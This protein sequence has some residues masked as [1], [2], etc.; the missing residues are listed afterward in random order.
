MSCGPA[1][2]LRPVGLLSEMG[3]TSLLPGQVARQSG[4]RVPALES[5]H[6]GWNSP[7]LLLTCHLMSQASVCASVKWDHITLLR[8]IGQESVT[9]FIPTEPGATCAVGGQG[10]QCLFIQSPQNLNVCVCVCARARPCMHTQKF[11]KLLK[12]EML[13]FDETG[14][15]EGLL[16]TY[17]AF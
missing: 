10:N 2:S 12:F 4:S 15:S 16:A 13:G 17:L 8:A 5:K 11:L 7:A 9:S 1:P 6:P 14:D 3:C